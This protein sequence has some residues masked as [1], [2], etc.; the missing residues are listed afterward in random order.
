MRNT[1]ISPLYIKGLL[2][3]ILLTCLLT[4]DF[5]IIQAQED[6]TTLTPT[7]RHFIGVE[8]APTTA[9]LF[10]A[11]HYVSLLGDTLPYRLLKPLNYDPTIKYP[12]VLCLSGSGGRGT[13]NI[14]Q[15]AGCWPA[16][17][18]SRQENREK[19]PCFVLVPQCPP[20]HHWGIS[21]SEKDIEFR[22]AFREEQGRTPIPSIES[23]VFSIINLIEKEFNI[24]TNRR[25]VTGQSMGG[26]G[27][28]HYILYYQQMFAAAIPICGGADSNLGHM[29]VNTP[30]WAFHGEKDN[31]I[32]VEIS[33]ELIQ[34]IKEAGGNPL[35]TT[36]PEADHFSWPLAYDTP[37]LLDWLFEQHR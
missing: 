7:E 32:P 36:F 22:K 2:M 29:I 35:F 10:E 30:V 34:A 13:D 19:Y 31:L 5:T 3:P 37:G 25:Y 12:M 24:D 26:Y 18:L 6:D 11:R 14:K 27:S 15:I 1:G 20:D 28:F 4:L 33:R 8:R 16:Q 21:L 23:S 17:I 9:Q